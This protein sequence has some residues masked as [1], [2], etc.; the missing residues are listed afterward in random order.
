MSENPNF[1]F[2]L[3]PSAGG[4]ELQVAVVDSRERSY[5]ETQRAVI[6]VR[7]RGAGCAR[8]ARPSRAA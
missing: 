3:Q 4:G 5:S 7:A 1:R 2:W 6:R 8:A